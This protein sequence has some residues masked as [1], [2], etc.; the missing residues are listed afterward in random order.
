[1][2][3]ILPSPL[4]C[5]ALFF[6]VKAHTKKETMEYRFVA[7]FLDEPK[8]RKRSFKS[9]REKVEFYLKRNKCKES[10]FINEY[11]DIQIQ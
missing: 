5:S 6:S 1:M 9:R 4:A 10:S 3:M 7:E 11:D 2:A 8:E